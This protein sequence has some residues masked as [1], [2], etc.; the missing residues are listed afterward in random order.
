MGSS[1]FSRSQCSFALQFACYQG[2]GS[3]QGDS[4][5]YVPL[6]VSALVTILT[7]LLQQAEGGRVAL[8]NMYYVYCIILYYD[9]FKK[10]TNVS[11]L[12]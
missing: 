3:K 4:A 5:C 11:I 9:Y 12:N 7:S 6:L 8:G 1:D 2:P 10:I